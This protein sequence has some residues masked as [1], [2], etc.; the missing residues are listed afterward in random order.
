MSKED[1]EVLELVIV[2][3]DQHAAASAAEIHNAANRFEHQR[4]TL[5]AIEAQNLAEA[6]KV[7]RPT[8]DAVTL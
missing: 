4:L 5:L 2:L 3:A 1:R 8:A 7:L 6:I